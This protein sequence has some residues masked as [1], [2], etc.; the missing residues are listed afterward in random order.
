MLSL[1]VE[2]AG[3]CSLQMLRTKCLELALHRGSDTRLSLCRMR[4]SLALLQRK[5]TQSAYCGG[6]R[7]VGSPVSEAKPRA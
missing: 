1:Q 4:D 6:R 3:Y 2:A 5:K 7:Q